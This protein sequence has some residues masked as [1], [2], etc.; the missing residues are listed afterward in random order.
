V[1]AIIGHLLWIGGFLFCYLIYNKQDE[2][3]YIYSCIYI[4]MVKF[5]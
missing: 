1:Y 4:D 3:Q 5:L 2:G